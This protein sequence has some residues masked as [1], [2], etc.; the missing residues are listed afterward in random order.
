M[1]D[2]RLQLVAVKESETQHQDISRV[3]RLTP[4]LRDERSARSHAV[5]VEVGDNDS[6]EKCS[7]CPG[8]KHLIST[9]L[10]RQRDET[11]SYS[12][13][14]R[15]QRTNSEILVTGSS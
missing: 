7:S 15:I 6:I 14:V 8:A 10:E 13:E 9:S 3:C 11:A 5:P 4:K 1:T 2:N 12:G